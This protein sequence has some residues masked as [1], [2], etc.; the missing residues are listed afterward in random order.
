MHLISEIGLAA[1]LLIVHVFNKLDYQ[2][3]IMVLLL[4]AYIEFFAREEVGNELYK[5]LKD[6]KRINFHM[7]KSSVSMNRDHLEKLC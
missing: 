6:S 7:V 5:Q 2:N 1:I 4:K 3:L